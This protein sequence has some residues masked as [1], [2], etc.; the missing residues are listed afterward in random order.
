MLSVFYFFI[1]LTREEEFCVA[2]Y[3]MITEELCLALTVWRESFLHVAKVLFVRERAQES[4]GT[5]TGQTQAGM[6]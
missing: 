6:V 1:F 3:I 4:W 5:G 2:L